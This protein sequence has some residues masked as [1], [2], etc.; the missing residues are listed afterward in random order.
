MK[1]ESPGIKKDS[2]ER[3]S[4]RCGLMP[5]DVTRA[6]TAPAYPLHSLQGQ[7]KHCPL[8]VESVLC[9][10]FLCSSL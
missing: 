1:T 7:K 5:G 9:D 10:F 3:S 6:L 8:V 4:D 2:T